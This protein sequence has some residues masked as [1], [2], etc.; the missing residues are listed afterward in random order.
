MADLCK[1]WDPHSIR[2]PI[3]IAGEVCHVS[4]DEPSQGAPPVHDLERGHAAAVV[5]VAVVVGAAVGGSREGKEVFAHVQNY[6]NV[7]V[8]FLVG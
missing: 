7:G 5:V 1:F 2:V 6:Q 8:I 3:P 4:E